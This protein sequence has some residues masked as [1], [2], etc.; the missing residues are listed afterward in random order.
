MSDPLRIFLEKA[1][2]KDRKKSRITDKQLR[3]LAD[4]VKADPKK[5]ALGGGVIKRRIA[6]G[7]G[8][9]GGARAIIV[10]HL[11]DKIFFLDGWDKNTVSKSGPEIPEPLLKFYKLQSGMINAYTDE[12]L[13]TVIE[14]GLFVELPPADAEEQ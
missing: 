8:S 3:E 7:A 12:Q 6:L 11:G 13:K 4:A 1:Y 10:F 9:S 5:G 2:N 14:K